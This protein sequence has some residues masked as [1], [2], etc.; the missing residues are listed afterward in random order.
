MQN[1]IAAGRRLAIRVVCAQLGVTVLV[2]AGFSFADG[3]SE[4]HH[5]FNDGGLTCPPLNNSGSY[6]QTT[7]APGSRDV[8]WLQDHTTRPK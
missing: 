7:P 6:P 4:M 3:H 2:A 5:W 1:S 8:A